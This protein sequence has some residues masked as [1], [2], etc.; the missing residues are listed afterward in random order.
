MFAAGMSIS[1]IHGKRSIIT[2]PKVIALLYLHISMATSPLWANLH[3]HLAFH[4]GD[5]RDCSEEPE[6]IV[7]ELTY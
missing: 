5:D 1:V 2:P 6:V 7:Y 4:H 3:L